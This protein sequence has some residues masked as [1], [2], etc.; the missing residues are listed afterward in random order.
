[1]IAATSCSQ[2]SFHDGSRS[3]VELDKAVPNVV[4]LDLGSD[5]GVYD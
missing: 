1:M 3:V 5:P 4:E 2:L